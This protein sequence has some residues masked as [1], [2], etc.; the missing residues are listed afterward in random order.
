MFD[1]DVLKLIAITDGLHGDAAKLV[2]RAREAV[3]GGATCIQLRLKEVAPRELAAIARMMLEQLDVPLIIN[4]RA[5]VAIAVGAAGCHLGADDVPVGAVRKIAPE[6][7]II[8]CSVGS[9][10]EVAAAAGADYAGIGPVFSTSTKLDAGKAIGTAGFSK[11]ASQLSIP[12][13]GIGG[14]TAENA[15]SVIEAGAA[16]VAVVS[17]IFSALDVKSAATSIARAIG[18]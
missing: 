15:R 9:D 10:E 14:I 12:C 17:S 8:G 7:F 16:G 3:E 1:P 18:K 11:L 4:D 2:S 5:D 13:V 6:S